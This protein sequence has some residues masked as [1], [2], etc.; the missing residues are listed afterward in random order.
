MLGLIVGSILGGVATWLISYR[1]FPETDLQY[2]QLDELLKNSNYQIEDQN[3]SCE[4]ISQ[5]NIGSVLSRMF[6]DNIDNSRNQI[7]YGCVNETCNFHMSY[8]KPWQNE[9][10]SELILKFDILQS[11]LPKI[12]T[13]NCILMP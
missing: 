1:S 13:A 6:S 11:G 12:E 8:C 4:N 5:K 7:G 9:E 2:L 10:C 3:W